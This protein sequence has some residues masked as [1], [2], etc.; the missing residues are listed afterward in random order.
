LFIIV[1]L[2]FV[3]GIYLEAVYP[4]PPARLLLIIL[5]P[6]P[7]IPFL[8]P[9]KPTLASSLMVVLF[10]LTG[11]LRLAIVTSSQTYVVFEDQS[12]VYEGVIVEQSP[13][14]KVV[15]IE[16]PLDF[17]GMKVIFRTTDRL[18]IN[19][20]IKVFGQLREMALTHNNPSLISWKWTKRLEG[21]SH[22][23]R[24]T[25]IATSPGTNLIHWWRDF[26]S[27]RIEASGA[28]NP[29]IIKALTVGDTTGINEETKTLFQKTGTSH[30]LAISGSNIGIV[31]GFFF[32]I[33]RALIRRS[34]RLRQR[35]DDIRYAALLSIPFAFAFMLTAG[36]SIPTI[37]ATIMI[38]V[39]MIGLF[40]ER[41]KHMIN[42]IALSALVILLI[43]PHS[44]FSP[45]FQLT[46]MS[47]LLI[48]IC[49]ERFYPLRTESKIL[50]WFASSILMTVAATIGSMPIVIYHFYGFNPFS[51]VYNLIAVPLMCV[52]AMPI[53]L[54][55]LVL[56]WGEYLLRFSGVVLDFTVHTL[57]YLNTGYIYPVVRPTL[58][59]CLLYFSLVLPLFYVK[60]RIV[61]AGLVFFLI[62]SALGYSWYTYLERFHNR[63]L[64]I[65]FI[66]VGLGDAMLV[67]APRGIR[68][69]VDGGG[70][71]RDNNDVGTSIITP[72]LLSRK[73]Q[74]I[75]YVINTHPHGDHIGGLLA[76]LKSFRV[77]HFVTGAYFGKETNFLDLL[78]LLKEKGIPLEIWKKGE[79]YAFKEN[80]EIDVLNPG[81]DISSDNPNNASLVLK[82][83]HGDNSFL[84]TGDIDRQV[85]E[86]LILTGTPV[87]SRVIKIPHH[88]SHFSNSISFVQAVK[89]DMAVLSVGKGIK[90]L[91]GD[92]AL[93]TYKA[94]SV[95]VFRTDQHGL[96]KICSDG[97]GL[98]CKILIH[99]TG[100]MAPY[101]SP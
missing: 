38:T 16:K 82:L 44:L 41:G 77:K 85:E 35:G 68:M 15:R 71:Y 88:G 57:E 73:I 93:D 27:R 48:V 79:R 17:R 29:G 12:E 31:T 86:K 97:R 37:R 9:K 59:E 90:G 78:V 69:L 19:D 49:S 20:K 91:P 32:F 51:I 47:V 8:I 6:L 70:G 11:M 13:N 87:R 55:G 95:P 60:K 61:L 24:G 45:S 2:S 65:H 52:I 99:D 10:V 53:S 75:D 33:T 98:T 7:F 66:D 46:F 56:P 1:V 58:F 80:M 92:G 83:T 67:E 96:I 21:I 62:P 94:L 26:L 72:I 3:A 42:T 39:F 40:S 23:I 28:A 101:S 76:V 64:C 81:K 4:C 5:A 25:I 63:T 30:I 89:P 54:L 18:R 50:R 100:K 43:Y 22:E 34:S 84:L 36:S 74:T 14:T